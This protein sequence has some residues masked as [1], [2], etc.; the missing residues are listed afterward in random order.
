MNLIPTM[1]QY[2]YDV[3]IPRGMPK[4]GFLVLSLKRPPNHVE[5][6]QNDV[7]GAVFWIWE[8]DKSHIELS[9]VNKSVAEWEELNFVAKNPWRIIAVWDK[10]LSITPA[11]SFFF[12][13]SLARY[14]FH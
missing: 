8:M 11:I 9:Q 7:P 14:L 5:E 6:I 3:S 12:A 4:S 1:I 2:I 13:S 10:S